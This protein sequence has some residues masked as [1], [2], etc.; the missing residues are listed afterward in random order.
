MPASFVIVNIFSKDAE[1]IPTHLLP[2]PSSNVSRSVP[3]QKIINSENDMAA[4]KWSN[5]KI[6][7]K[8]HAVPVEKIRFNH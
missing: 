2:Q 4:G 6:G 1:N 5:A 7:K 8:S 3:D